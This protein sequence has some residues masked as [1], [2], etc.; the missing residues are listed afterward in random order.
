M[1]TEARS[2]GTLAVALIAALMVAALAAASQA[3]ASTL[4]ACVKKNGSAKV[5]TKKPKCKKGEKLLSWN[6]VGPAGK[7]GEKGANGAN[8][9]NGAPGQPQK[10]VAFNTG[11][12][13]GLSEPEHKT[14][15]T[16]EGVSVRIACSTVLFFDKTDLEAVGSAGQVQSGM[17][18]SNTSN[19]PPETEQ[20]GVYSA[21]VTTSGAVF[22]ELVSNGGSP[23]GNIAHVNASII[24]ANSVIVID[25]YVTVVGTP[26]CTTTGIAYSIP[27]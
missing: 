18:S 19:K 2:R 25:A 8:G 9:T 4:Y 24:T 10:A 27:L 16:F 13:P 14:V 15:A 26:A 6:T 11:I 7:N 5:Y 22:A 23:K 20:K 17:V 12:E 1:S 21:A 3:Q